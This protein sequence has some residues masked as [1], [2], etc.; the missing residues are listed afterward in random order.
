LPYH[1]LG[2]GIKRA[3]TEWP[4]IEFIDD[5]EGCLFTATIHRKIKGQIGAE[6]LSKTAEKQ[7]KL[8]LSGQNQG[9]IDLLNDL[10]KGNKD[11]LNAIEANP[12]ADYTTLGKILGSS[13]AT[14]K[15][16]IQ[17]LKIHS[18][19]KRVGSK[20]TGHWEILRPANE[21]KGYV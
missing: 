21:N 17:K 1:G 20:K 14:V 18:I 9:K 5:R 16:H 15:R 4:D 12:K 8:D 7:E 13:E 3:L 19:V 11:L 10:I 6:I 2:S